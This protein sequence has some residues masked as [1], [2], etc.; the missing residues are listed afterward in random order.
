MQKAIV[1]A[2]ITLSLSLLSCEE[3]RINQFSEDIEGVWQVDSVRRYI[4][5][6]RFA[7]TVVTENLGIL[8]FTE[9]N[10]DDYTNCR[11]ERRAPDGTVVPFLYDLESGG[12]FTRTIILTPTAREDFFVTWQGEYE[13]RFSE[14]K[15]KATLFH[16]YFNDTQ[17]EIYLSR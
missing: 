16:Y 6:L 12:T 11:M 13:L 15:Q 10:T 2:M 17:L 7:D 8:D 9:C 4:T 14:K 3:L 5:L 1:L